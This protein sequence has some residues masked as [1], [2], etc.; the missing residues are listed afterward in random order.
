MSRE[1]NKYLISVNIFFNGI[2]M[3]FK[4][5]DTFLKYLAFPVL[6]QLTGIILILVITYFYSINIANLMRQFAFFDNVLTAFTTLL[7]LT[8]PAFFIFCKAFYDYLIALAA[9]NSIANNLSSKGKNKVLDTK[10]HSELIKRR[11]LPYILLLLVL[12]LAYL[13]GMLPVFW[14]ILAVF[15]VYSSLSIQVF[16]LE[17]NTGPITAIKRSFLLVKNNFWATT[18]LLVLLFGF[19][20]LLLPNIIT[21]ALDKVSFIYYAAGP[22][23]KYFS[24]LPVSEINSFLKSYHIS[25]QMEAYEMARVYVS[26]T[27]AYVVTAF[28]LPIRSCCCT[29]WYKHLD[30]EKIEENRKATKLDGR[31]EL[32]KIIKKSPKTN[33][34]S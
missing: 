6:G 29:L 33:K 7:V 26:S 3:Y 1:K 14:V 23:E 17:E 2:G 12:S 22:A 9:L 30:D 31:T 15:L 8:L 4:H 11:A 21:W 34:E 20:Y 5:L 28:T 16:T 25:Y 18:L 19:T 24:L 27:I 32:K 13:A 10:V